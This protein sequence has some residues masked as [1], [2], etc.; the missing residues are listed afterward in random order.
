[1][2]KVILKAISGEGYKNDDILSG[3]DL[4]IFDGI[5]CQNEFSEYSDDFGDILS[6]GYMDFRFEDGVLYT[7]TEYNSTRILTP[8]ECHEICEET[9][10]Q[11]SDG[12]GEGFEQH[13]CITKDMDEYFVSSWYH[14]QKIQITQ[15][16]E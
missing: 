14:G 7:Y 3:S 8:D 12:I 5:D 10:G 6:N 1:M 2:V 13:P 16:E 9:Q 15:K 4:R 11:W